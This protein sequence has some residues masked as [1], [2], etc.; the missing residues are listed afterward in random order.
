[1]GGFIVKTTN[2]DLVL[3]EQRIKERVEN[4][5]TID[6]WCLNNGITKY[7]YYYWNRRIRENQ[8]LE[9][10]VIFADVTTNLSI[11]TLQER[12]R[13]HTL[14]FSSSL[15]ISISQFQTILIQSH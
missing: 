2:E 15:K 10:V 3:W 13:L 7:R 8:K 6:E 9:E 14:I 11:Q 1:M 4:G 12:N 5:L